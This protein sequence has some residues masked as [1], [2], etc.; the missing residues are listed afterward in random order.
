MSSQPYRWFAAYRSAAL[1]RDLVRL[2]G[3]IDL[4]L[5]SIEER[6]DGTA[7]L[8]DLEF[9]EIQAALLALQLLSTD[10]ALNS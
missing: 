6:L 10:E 5:K 8:E 2:R 7:K 3:R 9:N 1:E 4:S